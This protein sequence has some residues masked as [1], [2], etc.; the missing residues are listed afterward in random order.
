MRPL[1]RGAQGAACESHPVISQS[2]SLA[3]LF[4]AHSSATRG[5]VLLAAVCLSQTIFL[6]SECAGWATRQGGLASTPCEEA[7]D[8][9]GKEPCHCKV[10][11][12]SCH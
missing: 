11:W 6:P 5:E 12:L 1:G 8:L 3:T 4:A 7:H 2:V 9:G 10:Y